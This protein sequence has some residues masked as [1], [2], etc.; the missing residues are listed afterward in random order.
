MDNINGSL[1]MRT[2][3]EGEL[4]PLRTPCVHGGR[5]GPKIRILVRTYFM[6]GPKPFGHTVY[7][8]QLRYDQV[9]TEF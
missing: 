6:D 5:G 8:G 2:R 7:Q 3:G 9:T 4:E 1:R